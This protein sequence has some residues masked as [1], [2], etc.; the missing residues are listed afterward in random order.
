MTKQL[1]HP[2][3]SSVRIAVLKFSL[4]FTALALSA[5]QVDPDEAT[6][7]GF[8]SI[9]LRSAPVSECITISGAD[10]DDAMISNPPKH[11]NFGDH[12]LLRVGGK[13]ESLLRFDLSAIPAEAAIDSATLQLYVN[14]AAGQNPINVHRATAAWS[15]STVSFQS[16]NQQF[17]PGVEGVIMPNSPNALKSVT[18]T[19]LVSAWFTGELPNHG[20]LLE[21]AGNKKTIFVSNDGGSEEYRPALE[22]CFTLPVEDACDP[23]PCQNGGSCAN[24]E[25]G[26]E[27]ACPAGYGGTDCEIDVDE[28]SGEPCQNGGVCSDGVNDYSCSCAAGW[29]GDNCEIDID[30]CENAPCLNGVCT[31][32]LAEYTCTCDAGFGGD[33]CEIDIDECAGDPCQNEGE[34]TD[35][36]NSYTCEC[37]V[38]FSGANCELNIDDCVGNSCE[39]ASTCVDG[40]ADYTCACLPGFGGESCE[41]NIDECETAPCLNDGVCSDGVNGYSC[42]CPAGWTGTNCEIDID[43]CESNPCSNGTC[44]DLIN[45]YQCECN[46]GWTGTNCD[47][48]EVAICP[49][50]EMPVWIEA[51]QAPPIF[52]TD[53]GDS[54]IGYTSRAVGPHLHTLR[55]FSSSADGDLW[56]EPTCGWDILSIGEEGALAITPAEH[57]ACTAVIKGRW[58]CN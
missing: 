16:F 28:C 56:E 30:E 11:Q 9:Q 3:P 43:E 7:G 38:G 48:P 44:T 24:I 39:N 19:G 42:A 5:C 40:I 36:S 17:A 18:L 45:A 31:D 14:G 15:E 10:L 21:T 23:D 54:V 27:C 34:C 1:S 53:D 13:D 52:C 47:E 12:P 2:I 41:I 22:V 55:V 26:Y 57:D 25:D 8:S 51:L 49:C 37:S 35:G 58:D 50:S 20:V 4:P 6:T 29:T 46:E 33:N 32:G